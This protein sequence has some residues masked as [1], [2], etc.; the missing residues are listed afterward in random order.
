M[1]FGQWDLK[2]NKGGKTAW[3]GEKVIFSLGSILCCVFC[4]SD[5][6]ARLTHGLLVTP[7]GQV[8]NMHITKTFWDVCVCVCV[9]YYYYF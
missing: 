2:K 9:Y 7:S 1:Q 8:E 6:G 3:Q 4:M 5:V